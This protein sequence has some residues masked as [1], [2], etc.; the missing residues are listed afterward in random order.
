MYCIF[1]TT[2]TTLRSEYFLLPASCHPNCSHYAAAEELKF[3][4]GGLIVKVLAGAVN[5]KN[6][7]SCLRNWDET[8][9]RRQ[10]I[11]M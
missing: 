9:L 5:T 4:E 6:I 1:F 8:S 10:A 7:R 11:G 3:E 2:E